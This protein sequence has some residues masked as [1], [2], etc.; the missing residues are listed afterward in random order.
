MRQMTAMAKI[1]TQ[2]SVARLQPRIVDCIVGLRT[3]VRL[4]ISVVGME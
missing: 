4:H 2:Y 1:H 3:R